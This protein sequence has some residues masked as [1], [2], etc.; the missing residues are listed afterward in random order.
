MRFNKGNVR[1]QNDRPFETPIS[2]LPHVKI[3]TRSTT[4][5]LHIGA[6][7]IDFICSSCVLLKCLLYS[8]YEHLT[9]PIGIID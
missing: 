5:E 3:T 9:Q 8:E 1:L 2:N 4:S 6:D 7:V